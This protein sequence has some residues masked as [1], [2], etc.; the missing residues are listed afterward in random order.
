MLVNSLKN[1]PILKKKYKIR[2]GIYFL[3]KKIIIAK[4]KR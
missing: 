3:K 2:N 1:L 4:E